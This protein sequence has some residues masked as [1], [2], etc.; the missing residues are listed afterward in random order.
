MLLLGHASPCRAPKRWVV[1]SDVTTQGLTKWFPTGGGE[2]PLG[3][4]KA[5]QGG[6]GDVGNCATISKGEVLIID[7]GR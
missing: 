1:Q 6:N 4:T 7:L 3:G 5:S 2:F